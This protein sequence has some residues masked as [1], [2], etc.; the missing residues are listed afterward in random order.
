MLGRSNRIH[1][2]PVVRTP[3]AILKYWKPPQITDNIPV[4]NL[5]TRVHLL[6]FTSAKHQFNN[7]AALLYSATSFDPSPLASLTAADLNYSFG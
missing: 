4:Q 1:S 6:D 5:S 3:F 7:K 2:T